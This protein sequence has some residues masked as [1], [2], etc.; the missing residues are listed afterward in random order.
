MRL[1]WGAEALLNWFAQ[2]EKQGVV[3]INE[4]KLLILGEGGVGKTT[5][6]QKI[7]RGFACPLPTE[8][9]HGIDIHTYTFTCADGGTF[10][11]NIWDFGGQEIY[12]ATHQFFLTK[13]SLY[14]LM[15]DARKEDTRFDYWLQIVNLLSSD[16]PV[17]I[18]QNCRTGR[19]RDLDES[20][21]RAEFKNIVGFYYLDLSKDDQEFE[22]LLRRIQAELQLLPHTNEAWIANWL[23]TRRDLE[24]LQAKAERRITYEAYSAVGERHQLSELDIESLGQYLHDLGIILNFHE[25][26]ILRRTVFLDSQWIV[27]GVY[28]VL[29]DEGIKSGK[30]IFHTHE[31]KKI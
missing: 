24:A 13:R 16:S 22:E 7:E 27:N 8:S 9:T 10:K 25:D 19:R 2:Q 26:P 21:M 11:T 29:D 20:G 31:A 1:P 5:L 17:I 28:E 15:D 23:S 3:K 12:H 14:I 30:G 4:A 18:V 6:G